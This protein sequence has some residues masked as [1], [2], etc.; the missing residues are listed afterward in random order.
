MTFL[1]TLFLMLAVLGWSQYGVRLALNSGVPASSRI[2]A[3][4]GDPVLIWLW[5]LLLAI[6]ADGLS[7]NRAEA[8]AGITAVVFGALLSYAA[9]V[10]AALLARLRRRRISAGT[11]TADDYRSW[12]RLLLSL[13]GHG[14]GIGIG[15]LLLSLWITLGSS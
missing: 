12:P 7:A 4:L 10:L 8:S 6:S 11:G 9:C 14:A 5:V 3:A 2:L 15:L 13:A 1:F